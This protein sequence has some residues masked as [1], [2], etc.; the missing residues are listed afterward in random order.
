M[1]PYRMN[2]MGI[3]QKPAWRNFY[4]SPQRWLGFEALNLPQLGEITCEIIFVP[5][6]NYRATVNN[7]IFGV[8]GGNPT[9]FFV[10]VN[11]DFALSG[12]VYTYSNSGRFMFW[13]G[14]TGFPLLFDQENRFEI[15]M[16]IGEPVTAS[17]NSTTQTSSNN[18]PGFAA[19][20]NTQSQ[21]DGEIHSLKVT[22]NGITVWEAP[23]SDLTI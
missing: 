3:S 22:S 5:R 19:I 17:I 16:K 6:S 8:Y 21:F 18:Y 10:S 20:G 23:L 14:N 13:Y 12:S 15:Y 2:P 7:P 1:I 11:P 9:P 4:D